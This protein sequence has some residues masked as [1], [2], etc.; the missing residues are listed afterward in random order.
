LLKEGYKCY[1]VGGALRDVV[2]SIVPKDYDLATDA[3]PDDMLKIFPKAVATGARFGQITALVLDDK[4]E[5]H[6]VEVTTF[7][8]ESN[9]I[10]G[11][12]PSSVEFIDDLDM[13]LGR[14]DFTFNAMALDL[15]SAQLDG[16]YEL[17]EWE[18]YDPFNGIQDLGLRVVRA[19]GTPI[20]RFKED[21]LRAFKAC[22]LSAELGFDMEHETFEAIKLALPV[23]KQVSMERV[24]DEFTKM[25]YN[26]PKPSKG[27]D[28]MRQ[29][30]LLELFMPELLEGYG[31][32]QKVGH[33][34]D[35][36]WHTLK[37]V[38]SAADEVKLAALF[39]DIAKPRCDMGNGNFYGHDVEGAKMARE[40]MA[41]MKFSNAEIDRVVALVRNHMFYF[42]HLKDGMEPEKIENV[43]T[44]MWS[45]AAVRR[46]IQRVGEENLDDL[47]KLRVADASSNPKASFDEVE[48]L[49]LQSRISE[50]REQDMAINISDLD[51]TGK[52]LLEAGFTHGPE[53]GDILAYLLDCVIEDPLV[54]TKEKLLELAKGY[55]DRKG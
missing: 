20:E 7:R 13:D 21:G 40:I 39:H 6:A 54:N 38:D 10:D 27:I 55:K 26:S 28:M 11:R 46:F 48:I 31:I 53:I 50:V 3:K 35:V 18:V 8:S 51:L 34:D 2:L 29:T 1:L 16:S 9:Y 44:H 30:G 23:A 14:R 37:T 47:F 36:Y 49:N 17:K 52:D 19:V 25:L 4:A 5:T 15:N 33:A 12:W 32:E 45:D 43:E 22:R 42:P 41:R 24:R